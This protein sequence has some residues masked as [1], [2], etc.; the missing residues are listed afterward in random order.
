MKVIFVYAAFENVGIEYLSAVL[1]KNGHQTSLVIDPRIFDDQFLP[2]KFNKNLF[3]YENE[4]IEQV[5]KARPEMIVFSLTASDYLWALRLSKRIKERISV[6]IVFGG[7]HPTSVPE[8]VLSNNWINFVIMGEGEYALLE[9]VEA[10]E[11]NKDYYGIPN[12]CI[13]GNNENVIINTPRPYI[14]DLDSLPYPD[15]DL[16]YAAIPGYLKY[17]N[18]ISRRGCFNDCTFCHNSVWDK[19]YPKERNIIR[20]RSVENVIDELIFAKKRFKI[21]VVRFNDDIFNSSEE[22]LKNFSAQY[23]SKISIP[24]ICFVSPGNT[25]Y[26]VVKYLK[27]ANCIQV[28][29]GVQTIN[30]ALRLRILNR[31]ETKEKI[32]SAIQL[33]KEFKIRAVVDNIIGLPE[34]TENDLLDMVK[35]YFENPVYGRIAVFWL[36]YFP[37]TAIVDKS[38]ESGIL[39]TES[40][41]LI[42]REPTSKG[43]TL[44]GRFHKREN[45]RYF[46]LLLLIQIIPRWVSKLIIFTSLYR[47]IPIIN[48]AYIEIPFTLFSRD[49]L[50]PYRRSYYIRYKKFI[51][52]IVKKRI[53]SLLTK[54]I[55]FNNQSN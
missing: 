11:Q 25:N 29:M 18:M 26:N 49:R 42:A 53:S 6:F 20:L 43:I 54:K 17:Y 35:F 31:L 23:R 40:L 36:N 46:V 16:Y 10:L 4:V 33:Y 3:D 37:N 48:P 19:V 15:K 30:D 38:L 7:I 28:N 22:W 1:R 21:E 5:V 39:S 45:M 27:E 12:V 50:D 9:L 51:P 2:F 41:R 32:I 13:K 14:K 52:I 8:V 34:E 47:Y 24:F 55:K 44:F